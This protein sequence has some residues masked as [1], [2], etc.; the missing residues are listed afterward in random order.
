MKFKAI[1]IS[2]ITLFSVCCDAF[3]VEYRYTANGYKYTYY[4]HSESSYQHA[5][6]SIHKEVEEYENKDYTRVD[7]NP[8][9][10][11]EETPNIKNN[12][13]KFLLRTNKKNYSQVL[14]M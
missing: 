13:C 8:E 14:L 7:F 3:A 11:I 1:I 5:W 9:F 4:R 2:L 6:C 10:L 12:I